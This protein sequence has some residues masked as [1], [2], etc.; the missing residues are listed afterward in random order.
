M[1]RFTTQN[2]AC[3][4][5]CSNEATTKQRKMDMDGRKIIVYK[6]VAEITEENRT[7]LQFLDLM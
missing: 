5:V 7:T 4:E 1:Y 6:P 2:S 3:I